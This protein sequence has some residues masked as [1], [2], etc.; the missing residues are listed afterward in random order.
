MDEKHR[1]DAQD[2]NAPHRVSRQ[3][4][5]E[6]RDVPTMLGAVLA[7]RTVGNAAAT[8]NGFEPVSLEQ[9]AKLRGN[10]FYK[11]VANRRA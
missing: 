6:E 7:A 5:R 9:E 10:R 8:N 11:P 1:Y 2:I 4:Q 3:H